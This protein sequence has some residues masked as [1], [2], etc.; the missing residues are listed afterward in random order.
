M[1]QYKKTKSNLAN[2]SKEL[3][4]FQRNEITEF[5]IYKKLSRSLNQKSKS[6]KNK[7]NAKILEEIANQELKHYNLLKQETNQEIKPNRLKVFNY[8][9][10]SKL[11]GI[12]F[13]LKLMERGEENAQRAYNSL[14]VDESIKKTLLKDEEQH[15]KELLNLINEEKLNYLGSIVLGLNDAL[16]EL[17]GTLAG[18]TFALQNG[19]LIATSGLIT[20][21]AAS[22]SM[23]AS[24][25]LSKRAENNK[26]ALKSAAYTG[27]TYLITVVF[28]IFPYL[29]IQTKY[30]LSLGITLFVAIL[31]LVVFN[32]YI[33]IAKDL[34]FKK[35]F[36]EMAS[37]SL[38]I[39][40]F[41]FLIGILLRIT[42]GV[43]V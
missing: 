22:L 10:I 40:A 36:I 32:Y 24:E 29:L 8:Y 4:L 41:S 42:L 17:T 6:L 9:L 35:R 30:F 39:A 21:I 12:T 25:F 27:I 14:K 7:E 23:A 2:K 37:I 43:S 18:L 16:V 13:G 26:N 34:S 28:L 5:T 11:F 38:G 15:E 33:S 20:G 19:L 1:I 3:L 31:I